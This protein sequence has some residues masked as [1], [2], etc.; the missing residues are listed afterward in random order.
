[1]S[2]SLVYVTVESEAEARRLGRTLVERRL[3]AGANVIGG[4]A[5]FYW[6]RG[7]LCEGAEA[8]LVAKTRSALVEALVARV[9]DEHSYECPCVVACPITAGNP[10]YLAWIDGETR[11][12]EDAGPM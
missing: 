12:R 6:W 4:V 10:D 11:A 3:A 9:R 5:S 1:M 2:H 8:V 7:E